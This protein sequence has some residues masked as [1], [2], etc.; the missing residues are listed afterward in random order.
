MVRSSAI[1]A[2]LLCFSS[3]CFA[4]ELK[5]VTWRGKPA[6]SLAG[7]IERG[8]ADRFNSEIIKV[9]ASPHGA[10][11]VLLDSMG[12]SVSEALAVSKVMDQY[13][14]HA[15][16]QNGTQCASACASILFVAGT[17][18]TV[19]PF[20]L[21]GQ[22]SCSR[23]GVTDQHCNEV[24]AQHAIQHGVSYGS[25]AAFTTYAGPSDIIWF[26]RQDADGWGI[27]RYAG[28][29]ASGFQK[30]EPSV[31]KSI[32][33]KDSP[34]QSAWRIDFRADGY[35]AF[36]RPHSD[37]KRELQLNLFCH[38]RLKGRLFLSMEILGSA[39]LIKSAVVKLRVDA[40]NISWEDKRPVIWQADETASEVITEIPARYIKQFLSRV[41]SLKF[42]IAMSAPY[43]PIGAKTWL[44]TSRKVL[45]FAANNCV[46]AYD[47]GPYPPFQ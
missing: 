43:Q 2:I 3:T 44:T 8:L 45:I 18:R 41:D 27:T 10:R 19:E 39:E 38:E 35:Q 1:F 42:D 20:G 28:E 31:V 7:V 34:A 26:S 40:D 12:G 46:T 32:S 16:V 21:L 9:P 22:H 36:L 23:Y 15:V 24:L 6:L 5:S 37:E 25:I 30:S 29:K 14:V 11:I 13:Q 4:Q 17:Y 47:T 33:G